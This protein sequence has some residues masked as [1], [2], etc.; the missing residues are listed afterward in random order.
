MVTVG[1]SRNH[2]S[3][4]GTLYLTDGKTYD[5][6]NFR[7]TGPVNKTGQLDAVNCGIVQ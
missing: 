2:L 7:F 3:G 6:Y 1:T 5:S 4:I